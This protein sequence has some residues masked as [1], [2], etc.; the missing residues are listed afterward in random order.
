MLFCNSRNLQVLDLSQNRLS[1]HNGKI[2]LKYARQNVKIEKLLLDRNWAV[3][4]QIVKD[5]AEECR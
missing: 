1:D 4:A 3:S 2:L 5:I